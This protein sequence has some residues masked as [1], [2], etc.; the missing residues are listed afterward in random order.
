MRIAVKISLLAGLLVIAACGRIPV[1]EVVRPDAYVL[2]S[3]DY[4]S[5][6]NNSMTVTVSA[7]L[8]TASNDIY[9]F[10]STAP[11][12][13]QVMDIGRF[14]RDFRAYDDRGRELT[15][16]RLSTNQYKLKNPENVRSIRYTVDETWDTPVNRDKIYKMC[17]T[18][19]EEDHFLFN[20]HCAIGYFKGLQALPIRLRLM[21]REGWIAGTALEM[22]ETGNYKADNYDHL[23]D[24]PIL[25]GDLSLESADVQGTEVDIFVYSKTGMVEASEI[26]A[27]MEAMLN[28]SA[29]FL[30]GLP[31]DRYVFLYHFENSSHGAW[32]HSYSSEYIYR[33]QEWSLIE[34]TATATA[35]HEFFHVVTPL[36]I[37]SEI[38]EQFNFVEPTPSQHLWLYEGVTEWASDMILL[39]D[40]LIDSDQ[41]LKR[42]H[43]KLV[44]DEA[45]YSDEYSLVDLALTSYTAEG[46][47][48]YGNI[49]NIG[50]VIATLLDIRII[51]L[52]QGRYSLRELIIDLAE[53]YG[54][55]IPFSEE[56]FFEEVVERTHPGIGSFIEQFIKGTAE[57]PL[58]KYFQTIGVSYNREL[59]DST[60]SGL[61]FQYIPY[62]SGLYLISEPDDPH[63]ELKRRDYITSI[64]GTAVNRDN[65]DKLLAEIE[66]LP[67]GST[68][69]AGLSRSGKEL[70]LTCKTSVKRNFHDLSFNE[71][72]T[73]VQLAMRNKWLGRD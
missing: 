66:Q 54:P 6:D 13:Y 43:E 73:P 36:N 63:S 50:A 39:H 68:Y 20:A 53:D 70:T 49:Y 57:L 55:D 61:G 47:Q 51:E 67:I 7:P 27:S 9:Q 33:E 56:T 18:S 48:Q 42:L 38:I 17:G 69:T 60:A 23:V 19:I 15:V 58:A 2:Y 1:T 21:P 44:I 26:M 22:D 62:G 28:A 24:S 8:L 46:Q 10:A 35:S 5:P 59:T 40:N 37:H 72:A 41:F 52:T 64:N 29:D 30:D 12:T 31:V 45:L 16:T 4:D 25:L 34:E 32:E 71:E 14:V 3:V 65:M 11:G